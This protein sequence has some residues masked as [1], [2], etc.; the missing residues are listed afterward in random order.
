[1]MLGL[2]ALRLPDAV[3]VRWQLQ[4]IFLNLE[5]FQKVQLTA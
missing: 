4:I 2:M 3:Q 5:L 1:M